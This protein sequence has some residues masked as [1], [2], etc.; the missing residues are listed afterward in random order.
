MSNLAASFNEIDFKKPVFESLKLLG[1]LPKLEDLIIGFLAAN[2]EIEPSQTKLSLDSKLPEY[3]VSFDPNSPQINIS[4][5]YVDPDVVYASNFK[6]K[7][8]RVNLRRISFNSAYLK[9]RS[10]IK[11]VVNGGKKN[12][13]SRKMI[14]NVSEIKLKNL[15]GGIREYWFYKSLERRVRD[16]SRSVIDPLYKAY[17]RIVDVAYGIEWFYMTTS[18]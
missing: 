11:K 4:E 10:A 14:D 16:V 18:S 3:K 15:I 2:D 7:T 12:N 8:E 6:A 9:M 5:M 1:K 17:R 13:S